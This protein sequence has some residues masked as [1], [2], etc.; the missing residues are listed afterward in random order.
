MA[1]KLPPDIQERIF[2]AA[3][4]GVCA[5]RMFFGSEMQG[6]PKAAVDFARSV[7]SEV[8]RSGKFRED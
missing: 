4:A 5:N 7:V 3:L 1:V 2:C 8:E 6:S